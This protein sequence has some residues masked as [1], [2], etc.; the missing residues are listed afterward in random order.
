MITFCHPKFP[1]P[2]LPLECHTW[3]GLR[4]L[5]ILYGLNLLLGEVRNFSS[6]K[7]GM[8]PVP[9][10]QAAAKNGGTCPSL[11][12]SFLNPGAASKHIL[13]VCVCVCGVLLNLK[14]LHKLL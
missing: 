11:S 3:I 9:S 2:R 8:N 1:K 4:I 13:C 7:T 5:G 14:R 10:S 6:P 12:Y